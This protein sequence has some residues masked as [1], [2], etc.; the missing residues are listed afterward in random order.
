MIVAT[1]RPQVPL[2]C[3]CGT[4]HV[5]EE[6]P[7]KVDRGQ[8]AWRAVVLSVLTGA[9]VERC[10]DCGASFALRRLWLQE[11]LDGRCSIRT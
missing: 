5:L 11:R 7:Y 10:A 4:A 6:W 2:R 3:Y 1:E 9:E 8:L